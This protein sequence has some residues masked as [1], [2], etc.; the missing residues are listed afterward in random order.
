ML[1]DDP[2]FLEKWLRYYGDLF[3]V[4]NLYIINHGRG[5]ENQRIAAGCNMIGIPGDP[6][7]NFAGKRWRLLNGLVNGLRGYNDHII[8]VDIDEIVVVD[9]AVGGDLRDFLQAQ[10]PGRVLTPFGLEI[11]HRTIDEPTPISDSVLGPRRHAQVKVRYSKPCVIGRAAT[12]ARGGHFADYDRLDMPDG[13]YMFHLKYC[14]LGVYAAATERRNH[15]VREMGVDNPAQSMVGREWFAEFR[16]DDQVF[17][18]FNAMPVSPDFDFSETKKGMAK[19]WAPRGKKGLWH[20]D[21][22]KPKHLHLV[23]ERFFGLI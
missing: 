20:F 12:L 7:K 19:S 23:P 9:P 2:F 13:L 17:G 16:D 3:G 14:D 18:Q 15:M 5:T 22:V 10:K 21:S 4:E 6:D 8:C 1:R 11:V